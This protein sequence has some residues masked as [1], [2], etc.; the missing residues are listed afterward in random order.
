M[1]ALLVLSTA[2]SGN[3]RQAPGLWRDALL[4]VLTTGTGSSHTPTGIPRGADGAGQPLGRKPLSL[5]DRSGFP[6]EPE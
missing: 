3:N 6:Q 4:L 1:S 5:Y 2:A